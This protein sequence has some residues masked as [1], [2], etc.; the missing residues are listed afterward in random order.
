MASFIGERP[1]GKTRLIKYEGGSGVDATAIVSISGFTDKIGINNVFLVDFSAANN[2]RVSLMPC[3]GQK[4]Y[5]FSYGHDL[6]TSRST[7]TL[8]VFVGTKNCDPGDNTSVLKFFT[9]YYTTNRL[10]KSGDCLNF[11]IGNTTGFASGY[12]VSM[13]IKAYN[14]DLNAVTVTVTYMTKPPTK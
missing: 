3:F 2:E 4:T 13:Q 12:L 8:L 6:S 1:D 5:V 11:S 14:P 7:C 9:D 10:Y